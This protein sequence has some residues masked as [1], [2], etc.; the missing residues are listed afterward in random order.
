MGT[1]ART[2]LGVLRWIARNHRA[3]AILQTYDVLFPGAPE[4]RE[5]YQYFEKYTYFGPRAEAHIAAANALVP[6]GF[7]PFE[8]WAGRYFNRATP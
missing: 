1:I 6:G 8:V 5:T 2:V 3:I 4:V 7:T